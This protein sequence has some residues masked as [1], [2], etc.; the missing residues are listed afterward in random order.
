M[1]RLL[2]VSHV[3]PPLVAGGAPRMAQFAKRLPDFGWEVTVLTGRP[4]AGIALDT[5]AVE[6][7]TGRVAIVRGWSPTAGVATRGGPASR[8][9]SIARRGLRL[10]M[11]SVLFPDRE[12]VW[13]PGAV[14]A[15]RRAMEATPHDAVLATYGPATNLV[16][17]RILARA[18]KLPLVVDFRDL[19]ATLPLEGVFATRFH[20][21][22]ARSLERSIVRA[23]SKVIAVAPKMASSLASAHG[24]PDSDAVSITNGFDP[25][26][27]AR[28]TDRRDSEPRPFR[29]M[30]TGSVTAHYNLEPF[31]RA[32]RSLVDRGSVT[33]ESLQIEFVGNLALDD[34]RRHGLDAYVT[35]HPFVA[36]DR[37]FDA[38]ARADALLVI[39][40]PGYYADNSYAAKVF[41]YLLTGKPVLALVERDGN[42][43]R[44][45]RAAGV[46][47]F[48]AQDDMTAVEEQLRAV[49]ALKGAAPRRID[50]EAEPLRSFNRKYLVEKLAKV[51]DEVVAVEPHG[52]W[53][54]PSA[55]YVVSASR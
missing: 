8:S 26:D 41:D 48:A 16:I 10:A 46:G 34:V 7:L 42:T 4:A 51:L 9:P 37:V 23:A 21:V 12:V 2:L 43:F 36:H 22:A 33:P 55:G 20:R 11:M 39:E 52:H 54:R 5:A 32:I 45:L 13:V 50:V 19:W 30:Y 25:D 15:A 35:V 40:T 29:L 17:G 38:L 49:L 53:N 28:A 27:A 18:F 3:F 44:L 24:V 47:Y 6:A 1:R 14:A 31:W